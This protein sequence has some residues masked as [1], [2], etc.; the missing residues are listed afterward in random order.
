MNVIQ[1][2]HEKLYEPAPASVVGWTRIVILL[3]LLY[4]LL[5]RDFSIYGV[6]PEW[7]MNVYPFNSY[8]IWD[9]YA[10]LGV[11]PIIDIF[12]FHWIHWF[13]PQISK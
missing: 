4:K 7:M 5:S 10:L 1:K 12:S 9:G 8:N 3:V 6:M 13:L 2:F 11:K